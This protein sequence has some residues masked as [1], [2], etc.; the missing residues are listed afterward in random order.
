MLIAGS[1]SLPSTAGTYY[2]L[3]RLNWDGTVDTSFARTFGP[4]PG[5][6]GIGVQ[7]SGKILVCGYALAV[8]GDPGNTYYYLRL[9]ADGTVDDTYPKR[10]APGGFVRSIQAYPDTDLTYPGQVRLLGCFP[11]FSDPTHRD[12][13]VL[14]SSDGNTVL[15]SIGD[16]VV[17]GTILQLWIQGDGK[18]VIVGDFTQVYGTTMNGVARL[19]PAGGLDPDFNNFGSGANGFVQRVY[20]DSG[21]KPVI[22]GYFTSINGTPCGYFVRLNY[23][24]SVDNT[25][26]TGGI[27][28]DD[29]IWTMFKRSDNTWMID[30]AFQTVNGSPR[31]SIANL[32]ANGTLNSQ[33]ASFNLTNTGT[34][35]GL[36]HPG[37]SPGALR[38]RRLFRLWRQIS[39]QTC[40]A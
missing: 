10:S 11:R 27:G 18:M 3:A 23:N 17:N 35:N 16:E 20:V 32:A 31:Q 22:A 24:G 29:R 28:A 30:G 12:Y 4:V 13:M 25:F 21:N 19:L 39:R 37:Q 8:N 40:P 7:T 34:R 2:G 33:Y 15:S 9:N 1:F 6:S 26:N 36:R 5:M 14:L 38:R